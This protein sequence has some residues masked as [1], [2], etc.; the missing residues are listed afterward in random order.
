MLLVCSTVFAQNPPAP[1]AGTP[2]PVAPAPA[3][4][5][6]P[7]AAAGGQVDISAKQRPA[8]T[9]QEML[10]QG[11]E[12][13]RAMNETLKRIQGLEETAKKQK[14]IIK[15]NCVKDKVVQG[16]VNLNLAEQSMTALQESIA[17]AD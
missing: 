17:R 11:Q 5:N 10:N 3:A 12:Y 9:P 14:D 6:V 2:A 13:F 7:P 1:P 16:K 4:G 15:L 8:L